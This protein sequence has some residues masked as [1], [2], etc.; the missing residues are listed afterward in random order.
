[1]NYFLLKRSANNTL[2][3]SRNIGSENEIFSGLVTSSFE[4]SEINTILYKTIKN[5]IFEF[6][7][8]ANL[9]NIDFEQTLNE[10]NGS[11]DNDVLIK[12]PEG[13]L[14]L[15]YIAATMYFDGIDTKI[16]AE[17]SVL[18]IGDDEA[19]DYKLSITYNFTKNLALAYGY[20]YN[21]WKS[22]A[23]DS[24]NEKYNFALSGNYFGIKL[25][26]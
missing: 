17:S 5:G 3:G 8:G 25:L 23:D 21:S 14:V 16:K 10:K 12:G 9:K 11:N 2:I 13:L 20:K 6:D 19:R 7:L 22:T 26:Y 18:A 15:P 1:V 4:Y 24:T